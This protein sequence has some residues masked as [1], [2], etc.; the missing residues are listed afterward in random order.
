[1][2][3]TPCQSFINV[4]SKHWFGYASADEFPAYY[5]LSCMLW[6]PSERKCCTCSVQ[7]K[8]L[9]F[10]IGLVNSVLNFPN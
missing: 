10:A 1:M 6:S 3:M 2:D 8:S 4:N 5:Q 7:R 9:D